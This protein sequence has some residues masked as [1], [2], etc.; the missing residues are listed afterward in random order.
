MRIMNLNYEGVIKHIGKFYWPIILVM[1]LANK[2]YISNLV[3]IYQ[4][5]SFKSYRMDLFY[6]NSLFYLL[7]FNCIP[8]H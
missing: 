3:D 6:I 5:N 4:I 8:V 1:I 7:V 2:L